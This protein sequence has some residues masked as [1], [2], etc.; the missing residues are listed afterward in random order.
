[1]VKLD[2]EEADDSGSVTPI[3][4]RGPVGRSTTFVPT[5]DDILKI[6]GDGVIT[7]DASGRILSFN[8]AA[9]EIFGIAAA[10]VFGRPIEILVPH[11]F[12]AR[13]AEAVRRFADNPSTQARL[14]GNRRPVFGRRANGEEFPLEATLSRSLVD[15]VAIMTVVLRDVTERR[16]AEE[17]ARLITAELNHRMKNLLALVNAIVSMSGEREDSV[18][19]Y[20]RSLLERIGALS[21]AHR[22]LVDSKWT[23]T[24]VAELVHAEL[25]AYG[26]PSC[27]AVNASGPAIR[28]DPGAGIALGLVIHEL[29]TNAAKHGALGRAEGRIELTWRLASKAK[30][31]R[32]ILDW[33]EHGGPPVSPPVHRGFGSTMIERMLRLRGADVTMDFDPAGLRCHI[34]MPVGDG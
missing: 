17:Q 20:K 1:M 5:A 21:E 14:M 11:R 22:L 9:E 25:L 4:G 30:R 26:Y 6:V 10:E 16:N 32:V 29:G 28:L 31:E 15:G 34:D 18:R 8:R 2:R 27:A 3:A 23:G 13:H 12:G 7:T 19:E 33:S 24:T